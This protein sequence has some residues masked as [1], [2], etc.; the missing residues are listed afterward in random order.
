MI[1]GQTIVDF[2]IQQLTSMSSSRLEMAV[3]ATFR[4]PGVPH[5]LNLGCRFSGARYLTLSLPALV[6]I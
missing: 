2:T 1:Q 6:E 3:V 4:G 5:D